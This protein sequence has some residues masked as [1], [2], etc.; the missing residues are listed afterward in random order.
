MKI[1]KAE[2]AQW[3]QTRNYNQ[4]VAIYA[5][6]QPAKAIRMAG[7]EKRLARK[8]FIKLC[9]L[10]GIDFQKAEAEI[11]AAAKPAVQP[12]TT[13]PPKVAAKPKPPAKKAAPKPPSPPAKSQ[14]NA[15]HPP[16]D[17]QTQAAEPDLPPEIYKIK[18]E[19][20]RLFTLRSQLAEQRHEIPENNRPANVKKRKVLSHS[21]QELSERI[22]DLFNAQTIFF[23][24]ILNPDQKLPDMNVLFPDD[25]TRQPETDITKLKKKRTNL[26]KSNAKD[27]LMLRFQSTRKLK[28]SN[29]LPKGEKRTLIEKRIQERNE[30]IHQ[31]ELRIEKQSNG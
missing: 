13:T 21:I 3:L 15:E 4:G 17:K 30:Q 25:K 29:P 19:H 1:D 6:Y 8:L 28:R 20:Q 27:D 7:R 26:M 24:S 11:K 14:A 31:I 22:E 2:I 12:K 16:A 23:K 9:M 10:A 5:K 18:K